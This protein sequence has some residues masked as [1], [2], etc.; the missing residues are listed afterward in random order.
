MI[1][2]LK[3]NAIPSLIAGIVLIV[4]GILI[5]F[6]FDDIGESIKNIA[7]GLMIL[8]LIFFL[9]FPTIQKR[10]SK[11]VLSLAGIELFIAL[12]VAVMF[13]TSQAGNPSLWL[14]LIIY[15]HGVIELI[16]GYLS[17]T[18][19]N[20]LR[21]AISLI[22]V[23]VGVYVFASNIITD[24]MLLNVLLVIFLAP[25]LFLAVLGAIG[26]KEQPKKAKK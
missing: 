26:L 20:I 18:K 10:K 17:T 6:V 25:G 14:G 24:A 1:K 5:V 22:L 11:L 4:V 15:T 2:K 13:M 3:K 9:I 7:I 12:L 21:F 16:G 19:Q 23:T 8:T